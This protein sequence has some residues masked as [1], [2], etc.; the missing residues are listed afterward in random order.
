[1]FSPPSANRAGAGGDGGRGEVR[2]Y[3]W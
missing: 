1:M 3:S 2:V